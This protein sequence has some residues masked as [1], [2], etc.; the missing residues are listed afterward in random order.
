[1]DGDHGKGLCRKQKRG[2][3]AAF[4]NEG[5]K[6]AARQCATAGR[7]SRIESNVAVVRGV[8]TRRAFPILENQSMQDRDE[9]I[10]GDFKPMPCTQSRRRNLP[11]RCMLRA[12]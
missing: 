9:L 10:L 11:I 2:H 5:K 4:W 1:L 6:L 12:G 3:R 8:I 7:A